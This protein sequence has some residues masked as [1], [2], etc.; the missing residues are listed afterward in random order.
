MLRIWP[1]L[2]YQ[3]SDLFLIICA[4]ETF[5]L[6][7]KRYWSWIPSPSGSFLSLP[8]ISVVRPSRCCFSSRWTNRPNFHAHCLSL[9]SS[10]PP[11]RT[12]ALSFALHK[13]T[14]GVQQLFIRPYAAPILYNNFIISMSVQHVCH[15]C[16]KAVVQFPIR[17]LNPWNPCPTQSKWK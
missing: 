12:L 10:P 9:P 13:N 16:G 3:L 7:L 5:S 15:L 4:M 14:T 2:Q 1:G 8:F 6:V 17:S 11:C